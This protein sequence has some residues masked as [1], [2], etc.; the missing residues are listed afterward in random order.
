M[1]EPTRRMLNLEELWSTDHP[2]QDIGT[3]PNDD[4]AMDEWLAKNP[5]PEEYGQSQLHDW[6]DTI[7]QLEKQR[8]TAP[9]NAVVKRPRRQREK[10]RRKARNWNA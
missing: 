8:Y 7:N 3:H 2:L 1:E 5:I 9:H 10:G 4:Y 6:T